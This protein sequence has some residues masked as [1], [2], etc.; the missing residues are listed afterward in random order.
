M[1]VGDDEA[2]PQSS[3]GGEEE[4]GGGDETEGDAL[5][6][7]E[8]GEEKRGGGEE[9]GGEKEG[10]VGGA[11]RTEQE[12]S[13]DKETVFEGESGAEGLVKKI[14]RLQKKEINSVRLVVGKFA[15]FR[16]C[17]RL[18]WRKRRLHDDRRPGPFSPKHTEEDTHARSLVHTIRQTEPLSLV[19]VVAA[20]RRTHHNDDENM[21]ILTREDAHLLSTPHT[22]CAIG[23]PW[24]RPKTNREH[25]MINSR[26]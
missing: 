2:V 25:S 7:T 21:E 16:P 6:G 23:C 24:P 18:R 11:G 19:L 9:G 1:S 13:E 15:C 12:D 20:E 5:G 17:M 8:T 26:N 10:D 22:H 4:V 14:D 3:K